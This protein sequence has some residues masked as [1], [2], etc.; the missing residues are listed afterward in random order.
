LKAVIV[1]N[2]SDIG[3]NLSDLTSC[4]KLI[5]VDPTDLPREIVN[6]TLSL[7]SINFSVEEITVLVFPRSYAE[8][9]GIP[10]EKTYNLWVLDTQYSDPYFDHV[11]KMINV[12]R[13]F[14]EGR[15]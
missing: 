15:K 11:Q 5:V 1:L 2:L 8:A 14:P 6:L 10:S 9:Q 4:I 3:L 7:L 13:Q 12:V